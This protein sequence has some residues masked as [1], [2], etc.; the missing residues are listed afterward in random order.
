MKDTN[1]FKQKLEELANLLTTVDLGQNLF[2]EATEY[3]DILDRKSSTDQ[4]KHNA[5]IL[6]EDLISRTRDFP[7]YDNSFSKNNRRK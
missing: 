6:I 1:Y 7:K 4:E 3:F 2:D 5:C